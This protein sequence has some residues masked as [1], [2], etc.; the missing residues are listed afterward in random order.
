M[1]L[2]LLRNAKG[3]VVVD[4]AEAA[5]VVVA[6]DDDEAVV[7]VAVAANPLGFLEWSSVEKVLDEPLSISRL[8]EVQNRGWLQD[9]AQKR[10]HPEWRKGEGGAEGSSGGGG[11]GGGVRVCCKGK[12]QRKLLICGRIALG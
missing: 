7:V 9:A 4:L 8:D 2:P 5:V 6:D 1:Y 12:W 10:F 3:A 11:S